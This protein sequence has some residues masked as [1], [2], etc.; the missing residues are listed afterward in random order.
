M[1]PDPII[2]DSFDL[3]SKPEVILPK[4]FKRLGIPFKDSYLRWEGDPELVYSSWKGSSE[5]VIVGSQTN[6]LA[7]AVQSTRFEPPKYP[8]GTSKPQ[9]K[10]TDELKEYIEDAIPFYEE[11]YANRLT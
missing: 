10:I 7:P 8:R 4:Y 2:I 11:M 5:A 3:T 6:A 1:D 9:W